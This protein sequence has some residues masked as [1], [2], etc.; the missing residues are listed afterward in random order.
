VAVEGVDMVAVC[1]TVPG[2]C[3]GGGLTSKRSFLVRSEPCV[4]KRWA[5]RRRR[6]QQKWARRGKRRCRPLSMSTVLARGCTQGH[7][8]ALSLSAAV[9]EGSSRVGVRR[10]RETWARQG[11]ARKTTRESSKKGNKIQR[12]RTCS[13]EG[14]EATR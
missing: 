5:R 13:T 6:R 4:R 11:R 12:L 7:G 8:Q 1:S 3:E 2:G 14:S 9:E 10:G